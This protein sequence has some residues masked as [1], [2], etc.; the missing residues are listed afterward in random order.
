MSGS[1][2]LSTQQQSQ[3]SHVEKISRI[4]QRPWSLPTRSSLVIQSTQS[5]RARRWRACQTS[6]HVSGRGLKVRR[7]TRRLKK[8]A[9]HRERTIG[10]FRVHP[11]SGRKKRTFRSILDAKLPSMNLS[12]D[13][14]SRKPT[15]LR[16]SMDC[17]FLIA[18]TVSTSTAA[19]GGQGV[20]QYC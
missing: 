5:I 4:N 18:D 6:A 17:V 10:P 14:G 12:D 13:D 3:H 8:A 1:W 16:P 2:C 19:D 20:L 9:R 15:V 7:T 11:S